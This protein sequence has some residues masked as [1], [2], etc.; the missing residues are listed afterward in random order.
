MTW[1]EV[2]FKNAIWTVPAERMKADREHVI[3]LCQSALLVLAKTANYREI[4]NEL[5]FPGTKMGKPLSDMTLTKICRD[6]EINAVPHGFRSSFRDWVSEETVFDG[7]VAEMALA[8]TIENKVEAAYRRGNLFEK[9]RALMTAWDCRNMSKI[10]RF[11][12][13]ARP[14]HPKECPQVHSD[15]PQPA[16]W[17]ATWI[18][19]SRT[20]AV[21]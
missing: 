12:T 9:R 14:K 19:S 15:Q 16:A 8:H 18:Y 6:A 2:D 3:P 1:D 7:T 5:V 21:W 17:T 4:S 20:A 11:I 10:I 13:P